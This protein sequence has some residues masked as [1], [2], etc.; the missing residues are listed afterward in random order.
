MEKRLEIF[1]HYL[2]NRFVD[3][4]DE[5]AW[6]KKWGTKIPKFSRDSIVLVG[7]R[8]T[9]KTAILAKVFEHLFYE[10]DE[11]LPIFITFEDFLLRDVSITNLEYIQ[12]FLG[13]YIASYMA[14]RQREPKL[15]RLALAWDILRQTIEPQADPLIKE[16]YR[17]FDQA[18]P[19]DE[20]TGL[21]SFVR[22]IGHIPR[23]NAQDYNMPTALLIDE[24][25]VLTN[26][27]NPVLDRTRSITSSFQK[28]AESLW[29]PMLISGS[30]VS[31]LVRKALEGGLS[32]RFRYHFVQPLPRA[33]TH[34]L[35]FRFGASEGFAVNEDFAEMVWQVTRGYPYGIETLLT[36][37]CPARKQFPDLKAL[38]AAVTY[39]LTHLNGALWQHYTSEF[40]KYTEE[41]NEGDTTR[42]VMFWATKYPEQRID[43]KRIAKEIGETDKT[44]QTTLE[45]LQWVDIVERTGLISYQGPT[46]PMLRRFIEYQHYI[47]IEN[48]SPEEALK[49][50]RD[51]YFTLLGKVNNFVG[52]V[53]EGYVYAILSGFDGR[54]LMGKPYFN[55]DG[56]VTLPAFDKVERRGGIVQKGKPFEMDLIAEYTRPNDAGIGAWLVQVKYWNAPIGQKEIKTF[57]DNTQVIAEEKGYTTFTPWYFCKRGYRPQ[58]ETLL[59]KHGILYSTL[60]QFNALAKLFNFFGLP[61]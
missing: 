56:S 36:T 45:K 38:E 54:T 44:V 51:E 13:G 55:V 12:T 53:A 27:Y 32:G 48:L 43:A 22:T 42:K 24:F 10:Q 58:A 21:D 5:L 50:W 11:V 14:F 3:R 52:P 19:G 57:M 23:Y 39:E 37:Q 26:V 33:Y 25:Q 1:E 41:L 7:R 28:A 61:E 40:T 2:N 4:H 59:Q 60:T 29:A 18:M 35:V 9:G 20:Y 46:D 16:T 17:Q 34:E 15:L 6:L 47:E 31:L 8:R 49:D 30:A